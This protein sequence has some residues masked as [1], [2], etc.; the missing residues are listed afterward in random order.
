MADEKTGRETMEASE[1]AGSRRQGGGGPS[2][3]RIDPERV[4]ETLSTDGNQAGFDRLNLM[5]NTIFDRM[6]AVGPENPT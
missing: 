4:A 6:V 5:V 1:N 2:L 3:H